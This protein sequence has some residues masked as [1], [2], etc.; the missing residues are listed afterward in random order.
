MD[1]TD[2]QVTIKSDRYG[3]RILQL[4]QP[5]SVSLELCIYHDEIHK[6]VRVKIK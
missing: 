1:W 5:I 3:T 6:K 2:T 4:Y